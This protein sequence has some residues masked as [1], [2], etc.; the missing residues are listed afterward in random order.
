MLFPLGQ[1]RLP[2][3]VYEW[4]TAC[5]QEKGQLSLQ[6]PSQI[7]KVTLKAIWFVFGMENLVCLIDRF[8]SN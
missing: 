5:G 1:E 3:A 4:N 8:P 7:L 2:E 6:D